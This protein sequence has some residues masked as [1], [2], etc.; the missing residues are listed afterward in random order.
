MQS[1]VTRELRRHV[2]GEMASDEQPNP[3]TRYVQERPLGV[4][5]RVIIHSFCRSIVLSVCHMNNAVLT[6]RMRNLH[7]SSENSRVC[8]GNNTLTNEYVY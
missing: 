8:H 7:Q 2:W 6:Q 4:K 5:G 3:H 1:V